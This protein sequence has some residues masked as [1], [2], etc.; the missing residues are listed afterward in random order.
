M[1]TIV[2]NKAILSSILYAHIK[3]CF[4]HMFIVIPSIMLIEIQDALL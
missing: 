4:I 2:A 1:Q 3:L